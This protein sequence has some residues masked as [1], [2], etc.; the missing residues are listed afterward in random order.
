MTTN[1]RL[2]DYIKHSPTPY[3]A[4]AHSALILEKNGYTELSEADDWKLTRGGK[5]YVIRGTSSLIAFRVPSVDLNG[6]MISAAHSDSPA[7]KIKDNSEI[8]SGAY[9]RLST[10]K[11][12]GMLC[13]TWLDRPLGIAGRVSVRNG[14]SLEIKLIDTKAP[15]A[16][17]PNV[18]IHMNRNANDGTSYNA[19]VDM[20]PLY[21]TAGGSL[22]FRSQIAELCKVDEKDILSHDLMLYCRDEG[23]EWN[24]FISAPRLDDLQCAFASLEAFV[25][26]S[27]G[28]SA[29][30]YCLFDNEEVGSLSKQGAD[31]TFLH[32]TLVRI[33]T[34]LGEAEAFARRVASSFLVSCDNAHAV[35]PNHPEYSDANHSVK[36]NC[37]IAVKYNAN[38]KY[39]SDSVST[40]FFRMIC[41]EAGVPCQIYANRADMA[42]GSTLG[43]I[44]NS[45]VSLTSVD[46]GLPQLAMHSAYET[47]GARDTESL[48]SA[49][50]VF[51][52]K[53]L[54][55]KDAYNVTLK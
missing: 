19:A 31:S 17:I 39:T 27:D 47:A 55:V 34:S 28:D 4:V 36:M 8:T 25:D 2:F 12:G 26:S 53:S 21:S 7:F 18:A 45:H 10:E 24:D 5:Y 33:C 42:G 16:L 14:D 44:S 48:I 46:I 6:F 37:G 1:E 32:D 54:K 40:A 15:C 3:H 9:V 35:H 50:K 11:Y 13:S 20:L 41:E 52:S 49:L 23:V 38:Q 43:N 51:F 22:S 29:P 30:V